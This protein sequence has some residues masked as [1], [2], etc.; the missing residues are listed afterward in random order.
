MHESGSSSLAATGK[1][2]VAACFAASV[3]FMAA[4][5]SADEG[6]VIKRFEG[7]TTLLWTD[8]EDFMC[9]NGME[10]MI[11]QRAIEFRGTSDHMG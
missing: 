6:F 5:V 11:P 7:A 3:F 4:A 9:W 10:D 2:K 1:R 8:R